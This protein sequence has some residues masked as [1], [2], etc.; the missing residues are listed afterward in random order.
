MV[1]IFPDTLK[2]DLQK[3]RPLQQNNENSTNHDKQQFA[4]FK[5][6]NNIIDD[7]YYRQ[8]HRTDYTGIPTINKLRPG[9]NKAGHKSDLPSLKQNLQHT[10]F[11]L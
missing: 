6:V 10:V 8:L 2:T 4:P 11:C 1:Y 5:K 3:T 9:P 7:D